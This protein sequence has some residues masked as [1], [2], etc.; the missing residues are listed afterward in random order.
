MILVPNPSCRFIF[1]PA[2]PVNC[3][4][5]CGLF[6]TSFLSSRSSSPCANA[7]PHQISYCRP[8]NLIRHSSSSLPQLSMPRQVPHR[9]CT[10]RSISLSTP[11]Q[12][13]ETSSCLL[14]AFPLRLG[15]GTE[16]SVTSNVP[17]APHVSGLP[18]LRLRSRLPFLPP[19]TMMVA[20]DISL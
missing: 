15:L 19:I 8:C 12:Y 3:P 13:R 11:L 20:F 4:P 5:I 14:S 17:H 10:Q 7:M 1:A 16:Y 6:R 18:R 9:P 2:T